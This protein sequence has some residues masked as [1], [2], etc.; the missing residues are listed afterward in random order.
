MTPSPAAMTRQVGLRVRRPRRVGNVAGHESRD[1]R[2]HRPGRRRHAPDPRRAGVPGRPSCGCS[3]RPAR[4]GARCRGRDTEITVED[5]ATADYRG[6]DIVLFSAG[7]AHLA[8]ARPAGGRG[9]RRGD[10]QLV[11]LAD[12]PRRCRWSSPR[13]TRTRWPTAPGASSP[14]PTAPRWPPCRCCG[15][16]TPR[17]G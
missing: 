6:L 1:C 14:T 16:C 13:S 3:P 10:R 4:P 7:K 8:G 11:G 2:G 12:G 17:P 15:R 9:R 5:A